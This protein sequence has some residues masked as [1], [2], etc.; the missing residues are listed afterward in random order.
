[1]GKMTDLASVYAGKR[2]LV[3]GHTGF[4]GSWLTTWLSKLGAKTLGYA[5]P[6]PTNPDM[7]SLCGLSS[8]VEHVLGDVRDYERLSSHVERFQPDAVFHLA[9]QSIVRRSYHEPMETL[10]TNVIGAANILQSLRAL[11]HPC[12]V[13]IVTSDKCYEN[14][15]SIWGYKEADPLGGCDPYSMSK[16]AAEMVVSSWRKTYFGEPENPLKVA[17]ARAGNVIGGGDW[18]QDRVVVDAIAAL[19]AQRSIGIRNPEASRPWQHALE[20]LGG[21][22]VLGGKLMEPGGERWA[23]AWNFGPRVESV[24][25]VEQLINLIIR[26]WGSGGWHLVEAQAEQAKEAAILSLT[27]EKAHRL[28]GWSPVWPLEETVAKTIEWYRAWMDGGADLQAL[29]A[30]QIDD[31]SKAATW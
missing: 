8:H 23:E 29:T 22:L 27:Y 12:A 31:Y 9:A 19:S 14:T 20:C 28:L 21:Y 1:M 16:A 15:N 4:K 30:R 18:A 11:K 24:C 25:T 10:A 7:F 26:E 17:T 5:L 3:T 13:V 6:P 2:V